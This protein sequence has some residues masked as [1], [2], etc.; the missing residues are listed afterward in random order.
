MVRN[1]IEI[2]KRKGIIVGWEVLKELGL[3]L[4]WGVRI[5]LEG[6]NIVI[7]GE[8]GEGWGEG[9]KGGDENG[10]DELVMGDVFE[11]EKFEDWRW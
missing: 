1:I 3:W 5:C 11:D 2:G 6:K 4:K 7:K 8:G 9:G 10:D